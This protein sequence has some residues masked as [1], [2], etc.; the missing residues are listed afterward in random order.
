[1]VSSVSGAK[2]TLRLS[3]LLIRLLFSLFVGDSLSGVPVRLRTACKFKF[4]I[5][6]IP[7]TPAT[8]GARTYLL[9]ISQMSAAHWGRLPP[10]WE[11]AFLSDG[12]PT[13][14]APEGHAR[15]R[16]SQQVSIS[17]SN[18]LQIIR[19]PGERASGLH[20]GQLCS[21]QTSFPPPYFRRKRRPRWAALHRVCVFAGTLSHRST[22]GAAPP[23]RWSLH[24]PH[25]H[26]NIA[27]PVLRGAQLTLHSA[28]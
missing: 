20:P 1:M 25:P 16:G 22:A 2:L 28:Q 4:S 14:K 3:F 24:L 11:T 9:G 5:Y 12:L 10:C 26:V 8:A 18:T 6:E 21:K 7:T 27:A 19:C 13:V 17:H 15:V 23:P